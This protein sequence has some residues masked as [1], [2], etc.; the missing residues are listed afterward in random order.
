MTSLMPIAQALQGRFGYVKL[1]FA[2][3]MI[4]HLLEL[5]MTA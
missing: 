5:Q 4:T 1:H 3:L 2:S